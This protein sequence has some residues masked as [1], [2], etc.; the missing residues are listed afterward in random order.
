VN[1]ARLTIESGVD[2]TFTGSGALLGGLRKDVTGEW[3]S[4]ESIG[5]INAVGTVKDRITFS[6]TGSNEDGI[7]IGASLYDWFAFEYCEFY[8]IGSISLFG[9]DDCIF[10]KCNFYGDTRIVIQ[11]ANLTTG[12]QDPRNNTISNCNFINNKNSITIRSGAIFAKTP[13]RFYQNNFINCTDPLTN[14]TSSQNYKNIWNNSTGFGNHWSDYN[15]TGNDTNSDGIGDTNLPW[16]GVDYYPLINRLPIVDNAN[17]SWVNLSIP[18]KKSDPDEPPPEET[19]EKD[20]DGDGYNDT[21]E[22][23]SGSDPYDNRSI[24]T[25]W[26]GDGVVNWEDDFPHDGAKW[27]RAAEPRTNILL[28][29]I[30]ISIGFVFI[31]AAVTWYT[32]FRGK[33]ILENSN[34]MAVLACINMEPGLHYRAIKDQ[35]GMGGGALGH[36]LRKLESKGH[37]K[38]VD[39]GKYKLYYPKKFRNIVPLSPVEREIVRILGKK[40]ITIQEI[41]NILKKKRHSVHYHL[42]NL[43]DKGILEG[44]KVGYKIFWQMK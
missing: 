35:M 39:V 8:S 41:A 1:G 29:L 37:I 10:N 3:G 9:S 21:F 44:E 6:F 13:N 28:I 14:E 26:D 34:T 19:G 25:D 43:A 22:L 30:Y 31:L 33:K 20:S 12:D 16:H 32:R 42:H 24:P 40:R 7:T 36:H 38:T 5:N 11:N 15:D 17:Q 2:I 27:T 23:A 18:P 4:L